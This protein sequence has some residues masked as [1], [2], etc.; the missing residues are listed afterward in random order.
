MVRYRVIAWLAV[1]A[2]LAYLCR[3]SLS[4]AESRIRDDLGLTLAQSGS[5]MGAFFWTYALFQVPAGAFSH[6]FGTRLAL[7]LF[8]MA[9]SVAMF[10]SAISQGFVL[11]ILAQMMMGIAQAGIFP[12]STNSINYWMPMSQRSLG[13]GLLAVGMQ[14]G[15][16]IASVLTGELLGVMSW[17][18]VF[19]L[20]SLPGLV[21]AVLF[22]LR[23]RDRPELAPE[24]NSAEQSLIE[25]GRP[26]DQKAAADRDTGPT[27]WVAMLRHP[28]L[29]LIHGQ[30]ICRAAGY[31][32]FASWFPTFL[33]Q[34]RG[35]SIAQSGY[36]QSVVLA[37][38]LAGGLLGGI[39]TDWIWRKTGNLRLSR[40][41]VGAAAL[42]ACGLLILGSWFVEHVGVAIGLMAAG[43]FFAS[44]AGPAMFTSVIDIS[45]S[46]VA[47]VLGAVNMTGNFAV[48]I[49]P[50]LVGQLFERTANWN[51]VLILFAAI[52]LVGAV[53]WAFFNP[54]IGIFNSDHQSPACNSARPTIPLA[55]KEE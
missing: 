11:L 20:F 40:S 19:F 24:V 16:I 9:W 22:F 36:L 14:V 39:L 32:F 29:W 1:A 52:Y 25:T 2:A 50:I 10:S 21:W 38:A 7:M 46:R 53:C 30:Q 43:I 42:G 51:L 26:A 28:G 23:F 35:V 45:G 41:G 12:A 18:W 31:M 47:Q 27:N 13:C 48:A 55:A 3:N 8:A 49:C 4:V 54:R 17:R 37:G 5:I 34:T 6:R 33:Q 15:A 44:L